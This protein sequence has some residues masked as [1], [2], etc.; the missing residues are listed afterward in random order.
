M[1]YLTLIHQEDHLTAEL[2]WKKKGGK[3]SERRTL[4]THF[5]LV[6]L[7]INSAISFGCDT[8]DA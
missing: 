6:A 3:D 1:G 7:S 8:Y 2:S 5:P 4:T